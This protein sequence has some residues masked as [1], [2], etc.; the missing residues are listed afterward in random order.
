M[1]AIS[2]KRLSL[3]FRLDVMT[4]R[5]SYLRFI[6]GV[7]IANVAVQIAA[8]YNYCQ[9][10]N[11]RNPAFGQFASEISKGFIIV[12]ILATLI[13]SAMVFG[14]LKTKASRQYWLTVP[15]SNAEKFVERIL[16]CIVGALV[17]QFIAFVVVDTLRL[18][19]LSGFDYMPGSAIFPT[20]RFVQRWFLIIVH[21][22][23][24]QLYGNLTGFNYTAYKIALSLFLLLVYL[25]G[26]IRFR[27]A[28]FWK[29]SGCLFVLLCL[30]V[31]GYRDLHSANSLSP[32]A[33]VAW[34]NVIFWALD[35]LFAWLTWRGFTRLEVTKHTWF[36]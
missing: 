10:P 16:T 18:V 12:M 30:S 15:A 34:L 21:T 4:N 29:V 1:Q 7:I 19:V 35:I 20:F 6:L 28:A 13:G 27:R 14:H 24:N 31:F 32:N 9:L 5:H 8:V 2:L 3:L 23:T 25:L 33:L 26:S 17:V 11:P 22:T 36:K